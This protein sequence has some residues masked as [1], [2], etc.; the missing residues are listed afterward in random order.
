M[1]GCRAVSRISCDVDDETSG[2]YSLFFCE[3]ES[4]LTA[5][6][7]VRDPGHEWTKGLLTYEDPGGQVDK[8]RLT[9][10]HRA[11]QHGEITLIPASSP[12]A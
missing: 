3:E 6:K 8:I 11:W 12:K 5:S 1:S 4:T 9:Q 10:M 2:I 7:R